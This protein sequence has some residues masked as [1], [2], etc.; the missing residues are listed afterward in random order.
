MVSY[1][2]PKLAA[3]AR[4]IVHTEM[5]APVSNMPVLIT[6]FHFQ[7]TEASGKMLILLYSAILSAKLARRWEWL[8]LQHHTVTTH[9]MMNGCSKI[10]KPDYPAWI[11]NLN[12]VTR[13]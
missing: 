13:V 2:N 9:S 6:F 7:S 3:S 12:A 11:Y 10:D 4:Q 1:M 5:A 8:P